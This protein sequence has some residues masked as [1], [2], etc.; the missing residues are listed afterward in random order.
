LPGG[1]RCCRQRRATGAMGGYELVRSDDAAGAGGGADLESGAVSTA[2]APAA[3]R[4]R[5]VSLDVFRGITVL[6]G[7]CN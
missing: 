4:H 7:A 2:P 5:L 6:V 1:A 3:A